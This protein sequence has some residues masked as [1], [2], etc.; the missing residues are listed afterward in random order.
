M[1]IV[2]RCKSERKVKKEVASQERALLCVALASVKKPLECST[3][4][5]QSDI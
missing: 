4:S 3:K 2:N 5:E 1:Q